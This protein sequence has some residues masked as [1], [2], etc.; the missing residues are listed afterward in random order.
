[1]GSTMEQEGSGGLLDA[2]DFSDS[3]TT[4]ETEKPA[5]KKSYLLALEFCPPNASRPRRVPRTNGYPCS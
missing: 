2:H 3:D 1:M 5:L 4:E